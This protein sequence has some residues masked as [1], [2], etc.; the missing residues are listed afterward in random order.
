[1]N[2]IG[3]PLNS[4][5]SW[6]IKKRIKEIDRFIQYP[7]LTQQETLHEL[8]NTSK[9]T[10][11][12]INNYFKSVNSEQTFKE[13]VQLAQYEDLVPFINRQK[14]GEAN[15]LW[16]EKVKWFAQS[17]GTTCETVKHIP[18]TYESLKHCHYKGERS[19]IIVLPQ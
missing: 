7:I 17:S 2:S 8:I 10:V 3:N 6:F 19:F 18:I 12:G 15:V 1:M 9:K 13:Q 16:P 5:F 14:H 4:F 11:F